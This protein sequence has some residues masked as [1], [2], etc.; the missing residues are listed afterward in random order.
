M[1]AFE[2]IYNGEVVRKVAV[3]SQLNEQDLGPIPIDQPGWFVVRA[4]A[5]LEHTY[6]FAST[7]PFYLIN[8]QGEIPIHKEA[9][10]FF[11]N[12]CY[13]RIERIDLKEGPQREEVMLEWR[14]AVKWWEK[15]LRLEGNL[16]REK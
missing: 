11:I 4:V 14:Q 6:R 1:E 10:H 5:E 9:Y 12:W 7:A 8:N 2:L 13:Q 3:D 16:P 15:R